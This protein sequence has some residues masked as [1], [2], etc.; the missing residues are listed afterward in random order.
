M[1]AFQA[2]GV[3]DLYDGDLAAYLT[4]IRDTLRQR[5]KEI[6]ALKKLVA[7]ANAILNYEENDR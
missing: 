5:S 1:S 6:K 7:S 4:A 3:M 2:C